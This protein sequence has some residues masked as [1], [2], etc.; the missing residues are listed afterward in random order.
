[1]EAVVLAGIV[2]NVVSTVGIVMLNKLLWSRHKFEFMLTLSAFHFFFTAFCTRLAKRFG[3]FQA[4]PVPI[5]AVMPLCIGACGSVA[6]MNLNLAYNSV[7]FYQVS[8]LACV[9]FIMI[10]EWMMMGKK[11]SRQIQLS[12]CAVLFGVGIATVSDFELNLTGSV[13]AALAVLFTTL[14]QVFTGSKQK[15][16]GLDSVQLLHQTAPIVGLGMM[17]MIPLFDQVYPSTLH[18]DKPSLMN[19]QLTFDVAGTIFLTCMFA[20]LVNFTNYLVI[21]K[22]SP[23]TYQVLGHLKTCLILLLGYTLFQAP[24]NPNNVFGILV[25]VVGMV[26][27]TELKRRESLPPPKPKFEHDDA[28]EMQEKE[29]LLKLDHDKV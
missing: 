12:L 2:G 22:T 4:K 16:L 21:G 1:V 28:L 13:F 9:P 7:G 8:K 5:A 10:L 14:A 23:L 27:Y 25:A 6:F 19:Y 18:A 20:A 24:F 26:L 11:V 29:G 17:I 3:L 15:E